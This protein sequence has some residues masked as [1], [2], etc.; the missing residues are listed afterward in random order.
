MFIIKVAGLLFSLHISAQSIFIH[1]F[2]PFHLMEL[3]S[4]L[5][6]ALIA[7]LTSF[8]ALQAQAQGGYVKLGGAYNMAVGG[9][10]QYNINSN[11]VHSNSGP[12]S[13]QETYERVDM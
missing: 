13:Y 10:I 6:L 2:T 11:R 9:D 12:T 7:G 4:S 5:K 3:R 8:A 1:F